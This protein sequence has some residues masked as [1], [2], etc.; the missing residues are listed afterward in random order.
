MPPPRGLAVS[1][2]MFRAIGTPHPAEKTVTACIPIQPLRP[3]RLDPRRRRR[4]LCQLEDLHEIDGRRT[5]HHSSADSVD[6][7][8]AHDGGS[9]TPTNPRRTNTG[10]W[11]KKD[12]VLQ[13]KA[14]PLV[15]SA[16]EEEKAKAEAENEE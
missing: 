4:F 9:M 10:R 15:M 3:A 16:E 14:K 7:I 8:A 6:P 1:H 13:M 2:A 11:D 12:V 5:T